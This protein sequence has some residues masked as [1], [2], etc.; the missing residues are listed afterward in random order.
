[1]PRRRLV[2]SGIAASAALLALAKP[3]DR[4]APHDAYFAALNAE[5]RAHG[6]GR[7][8][9][10]LDLDRLDANAE[11]LHRSLAPGLA[12]RVVAKSLPSVPLLSHLLPKLETRRLMVF[13]EPDLRVLAAAFPDSDLLVGKP[14]P[15]QAAANFYAHAPPAPFDPSKQLQWLIDSPERLA[16]YLALA[17]ERGVQVAVSLELDVGLHRGGVSSPAELV[18][19]LDTIAAHRERLRLA[20]MMGYDAHVAKAPPVLSSVPGALSDA[21]RIYS[22]MLDAGRKAHPELFA[23]P[24]ALNGAGSQTFGLYAASGPLNEVS[25]GSALVKPTDFD[26]ASLANFQPAA[27]IATPVLKKLAG[28][29]VPFVEALGPLW[30]TWD[31]N[32]AETLFLYG[33]GWRARY[34]SP[35]GLEENPLYGFSTNQAFVNAS[36]RA[37]LAVDDWVFLQPTQ[38]EEVLRQFGDLWIVRGG[39]VVDRWAALPP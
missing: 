4:G 20:G 9:L 12:L 11:R 32:R 19:M 28:T 15:A 35:A 39:K 17:N 36:V 33:G 7:P 25:V 26:V 1:V 2:L 16:Q 30:S 14:L 31:P 27:F 5:L 18:S 22:A 6:E 24:L 3:R 10:L 38:S 8:V 13:H 21:S 23:A 37:G 29:K 34:A